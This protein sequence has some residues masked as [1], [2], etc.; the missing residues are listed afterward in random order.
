MNR[1]FPLDE[2]LKHPSES[3]DKALFAK[4][5]RYAIVVP[6]I[7]GSLTGIL[8]ALAEMIPW[9]LST[10]LISLFF[11]IWLVSTLA[12]SGFAAATLLRR[13]NGWGFLLL[14]LGLAGTVT[15]LLNSMSLYLAQLF[16]GNAYI[17]WNVDYRYHLMHAQ[18]LIA[19]EGPGSLLVASGIP[20]N[21]HIGP[22]GIAAS[23]KAGLNIPIELTS[24]SL[25][26]AVS[27]ISLLI[28]LTVLFV[29]LGIAES[30]AVGS[31]GITLAFPFLHRGGGDF[32]AVALQQGTFLGALFTD[33]T[34]WYFSPSL[35][36]NS[37]FAFGILGSA[38][39]LLLT[40]QRFAPAIL[41]GL[42]F[43]SVMAT[44]PQVAILAPVILILIGLSMRFGHGFVR[45]SVLIAIT[46]S[47]IVNLVTI[48]AF[49][50]LGKSTMGLSGLQI[51]P[52]RN[53]SSDLFLFHLGG[54]GGFVVLT[55]LGI[56]LFRLFKHRRMWQSPQILT[57][58]IF[59]L[60]I[61]VTIIAAVSTLTFFRFNAPS[62]DIGSASFTAAFLQGLPLITLL[63]AALIFAQ[64]LSG[65]FGSKRLVRATLISLNL[66]GLLLQNTQMVKT[67]IEPERGYEFVDSFPVVA[68]LEGL[69]S[70][71]L[72]IVS[73]LAE[74]AQ[75]FLRPGDAHYIP[76]A[77]GADFWIAA[78]RYELAANS[79]AQRRVRLAEKFFST[80]WS[81]WHMDFLKET[82]V[83]HALIS[84]RCHPVWFQPDDGKEDNGVLSA[85][86]VLLSLND[87]KSIGAGGPER[88]NEFSP[89]E[90]A[91]G[92][93]SCLNSD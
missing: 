45:R 93:S 18:S 24:F 55:A 59:S 39:T 65:H 91:Y 90:P 11:L 8:V 29:R 15:A 73:D 46:T 87:M 52:S 7:S 42:A 35:M 86:W 83:T 68:A 37:F 13:A 1:V 34:S 72:L 58:S 28:G 60:G 50:G 32:T 84:P 16:S 6:A 85:D 78:F 88:N 77:T 40:N 33:Y 54:P 5:L 41:S 4:R 31:I 10:M 21:Y 57:P 69:D 27:L 23:L 61:G 47:T 19:A 53:V 44:K 76:A 74:P 36:L 66:L 89:L 56:G 20:I 92:L 3:R 12:F 82:G 70:K 64:V 49:L 75:N 63:C 38:L 14:L 51:S 25:V 22:A 9:S 80:N 67:V 43:G 48:M 26:P 71:H 30:I 79:E 2:R 81:A 62:D 17:T